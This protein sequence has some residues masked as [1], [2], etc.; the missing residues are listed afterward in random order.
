M[1]EFILVI[2]QFAV[3]VLLDESQDLLQQRV[4]GHLIRSDRG[5]REL[6]PFAQV[7]R[8][9]FRRR[10]LELVSKA[11]L[12]AADDHPLLL[13]ASAAGQMEVED[14]VGENHGGEQ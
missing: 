1:D 2:Q 9:D 4:Q 14:G 5:N 12:Q 8:T 11:R 6:R 7:L 10:D 13:Q 3:E